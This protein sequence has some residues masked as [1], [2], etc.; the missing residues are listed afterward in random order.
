MSPEVIKQSGYDHKADIWSLGA[1]QVLAPQLAA[2]LRHHLYRARH[3]RASLRRP[4]PHEG[5]AHCLQQK[6]TAGS[7][8]NSQKPSA[9]ARREQ[10]FAHFPRFCFPVPPARSSSSMCS[11]AGLDLGMTTATQGQ[12]LAETQIHQD[13]SQSLLP[14]GADRATRKMAGGGRSETAGGS[15]ERSWRVSMAQGLVYNG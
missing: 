13:R 7:L 6:L 14:D 5:D 15:A 4:A 10:I 1:L 2:H 3:G 8:S 11:M 9:P 12:G